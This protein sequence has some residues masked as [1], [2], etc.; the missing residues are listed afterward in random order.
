[1]NLDQAKIIYRGWCKGE[2]F[3]PETMLEAAEAMY[4]TDPHQATTLG[5]ARAVMIH[6]KTVYWW[7]ARHPSD[8][9]EGPRHG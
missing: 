2:R 5:T 3:D 4:Q 9:F 6:T 1:M 8:S 7:L